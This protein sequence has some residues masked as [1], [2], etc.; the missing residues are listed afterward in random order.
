MHIVFI[1][2]LPNI[3]ILPRF[4]TIVPLHKA[5]ILFY[6][7]PQNLISTKSEQ[8]RIYSS[9][10]AWRRKQVRVMKIR[11]LPKAIHKGNFDGKEEGPLN[12]TTAVY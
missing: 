6:M 5:I 3:F 7:K 11:T 9:N 2:V 1:C 10:F 12:A 8:F 4:Q